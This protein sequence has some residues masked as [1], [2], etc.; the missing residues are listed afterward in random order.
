MTEKAKA[1]PTKKHHQRKPAKR[2]EVFP[3]LP[4]RLGRSS[5]AVAASVVEDGTSC[6]IRCACIVILTAGF[7]FDD[8]GDFVFLG[9][10]HTFR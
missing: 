9:D 5:S 8:A 4:S 3:L 6:A 1:S 2:R 10:Q 7:F